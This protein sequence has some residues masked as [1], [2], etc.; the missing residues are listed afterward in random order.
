MPA[1]QLT[2]SITD[3][4]YQQDEIVTLSKVLKKKK[5]RKIMPGNIFHSTETQFL[6]YLISVSDGQSWRVKHLYKNQSISNSS[7]HTVTAS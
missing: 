6:T 3:K 7:E 5:K 4:Q 2:L 1:C